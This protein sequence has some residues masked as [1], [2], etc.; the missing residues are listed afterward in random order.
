MLNSSGIRFYGDDNL[1][2][3]NYLQGSDGIVFGSGEAPQISDSYLA[4]NAGIHAAANHARVMFNTLVNCSAY[5]DEDTRGYLPTEFIVANNLLQGNSGTFVSSAA[6]AGQIN[7]TWWTN[8]FWGSASYTGSSAGGYWHVNPQ[9][10]TNTAVPFHIAANSPATNASYAAIAEVV[11]DMDGQLRVGTP[12]IGADEYSTATVTRLPLGT[13]DVGP[14]V[15]ATNFAVVAMPWIQTVMPG[16][17]T[18]YTNLLSAYN[19]FTNAVTLTVTNLPAGVSAT[20]NPASISN[21]LGSSVLS[22][23]ASNPTAP[24]R[25]TLFITAASATFTNTTTAC[26]TVGN[27]PANWTDLDLNSPGQS[28]STDYYLNTFAV[29]GGGAT[30]LGA[31]DQFHFVYQ[32]WTNG[33]VLT[34]RVSTQPYTA[35]SAKSGVMLRESTNANAKFVD[36]VVTPGA[37]K[38]EARA[39]TGGS[40]TTIAAFSGTNSPVGTNSPCWVRLVR[41][42]DAF[43]GYSSSNG[44]VWLPLGVATTTLTNVF[45]GLAVCAYDNTRLNTS[46]FDSVSVLP[47]N[48]PPGHNF[49]LSHWK[50]QLPVNTNG[51]LSG[52]NLGVQEILTPQLVA[53]FTDDY[54]YSAADGAMT[55]WSPV[56]GA[57]TSGTDYPRSELREMLNPNDTSVDWRGYGTHTLSASCQVLQVPNSGKVCIG[58]IKEFSGLGLPLVFLLY[59]N[60][61]ILGRVK[62]VSTDDTSNYTFTCANVGLSNNISYQV[63]MVNGLISIAVNGVTNSLDVFQ[64]DPAWATNTLYFKAGAYC[65]DNV[66][67]D[68]EGARVAFYS[69]NVAHAPS[70]TNQP[71]SS[72]VAPGGTATFTVGATD[73]TNMTYQW[74]FNAASLPGKTSASLAITNVSG[75]NVGNYS[76][77]VSDSLGSVTSSVVTLVTNA[78]PSISSQPASQ[79]LAA[80]ATATFSVG[81][82]GSGPLSYQWLFN[83]TNAVG[84]NTNVLSLVNVQAA[85]AGGYSVVVTNAF[86]AV[87]SSVASLAVYFIITNVLLAD[88]WLDGARTNTSLP[89]DS[90]WYGNVS[91]SLV[92]VT[93]SLIGTTDP[94][95][96]LTWWTYFTTNAA[97][98]V[99]LGVSDTLRL[100][101]AFIPNGV[102]ASNS[103]RGIRLGVYNSA[104]GTRTLVEG[105]NPSGVNVAGYMLSLNL[106]QVFGGSPTLQFLERTNL[107]DSNLIGTV[108]DYLT[109]GSG[110]PLAGSAAFGNDVPYVLE[111]LVKRNAGSVDLTANISDP[112]GWAISFAAT[113]PGNFTT[114]FDTFVF[115]PALNAQTA[116]NF[117][118]TEFKVELVST[119]N[120]PPVP[121]NHTAIVKQNQ[122]I[123]IPVAAL[124]ATDT[125]PDGDSLT[126][127]AVSALSTNNG[128]VVLAGGTI[129]YTPPDGYV[130]ADRFSYTLTDYRGASSSGFVLVTVVPPPVV[131]NVLLSADRS[132]FTLRGAGAASQPYVLLTATNLAPPISWTPIATNSAA[133]NGDFSFTDLQAA[134]FSQR[135]YRV[136]SP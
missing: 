4:A 84:S 25:Y 12:D 101:L 48:D 65:Q 23:T 129:T 19:G 56:T 107:P 8:I 121:A 58:Q 39:A 99:P 45:A 1:I 51:V 125:D 85:S 93:N 6:A 61:T 110:G 74:Y 92:A 104:N 89:G 7:F 80:G 96:T 32:P 18:G 135:F 95:N 55:F 34:A 62:M 49:D 79:S 78:A 120:H 112:N 38:M 42:G 10:P 59:D 91:S 71:A 133:A 124:L 44:V 88:R 26:L 63:R 98:P 9:L 14:Y 106:G 17:G 50:L 68:L 5:F 31:S 115:R 72:A 108:N 24:G 46:T 114:A 81:A 70:I 131:T 127:T 37:I 109:L 103:S 73:W 15:A 47:A 2:I 132:A 75:A 66:G 33:V 117:T 29:K 123:V 54:F 30:L 40:A 122:I 36:V 53:G 128:T 60:G 105:S 100:T 20:F 64:T 126:I 134:N 90:A 11:T 35:A 21:G 113:D 136:V 119:N 69:L 22:L 111:L 76:V 16:R 67:T 28:G 130:G 116:T 86:G 52:T 43:M 94:A 87:T 83:G 27:L 77:V 57:T 102:N 41:A 13:N 82:F 118:F 3:N 97:S